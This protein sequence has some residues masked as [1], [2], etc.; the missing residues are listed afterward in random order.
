MSSPSN[1]LNDCEIDISF[2]ETSSRPAVKKVESPRKTA[3]DSAL[4]SINV[5]CDAT[6]LAVCSDTV[7]SPKMRVKVVKI[8]KLPLSKGEDCQNVVRGETNETSSERLEGP[9][10]VEVEK[11]VCESF[12]RRRSERIKNIK[13]V[14]LKERGGQDER[15]KGKGQLKKGNNKKKLEIKGIEREMGLKTVDGMQA[16]G[17]TTWNEAN[18]EK[19]KR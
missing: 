2:K 17:D 16:V 3:T 12:P 13:E 1:S 15:H 4:S 11:K 14:T 5:S 7:L 8:G 10:K 19:L 18:C 6:A 9:S